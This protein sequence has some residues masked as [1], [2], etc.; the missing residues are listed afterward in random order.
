MKRLVIIGGGFTGSLVA[1]ALENR[2]QTT[3]IDTK[4]FFEFTPGILRLAI[5]PEHI[6][7]LQNPHRDYLEKTKIIIDEVKYISKNSILLKN[8]KIPF[9]YLVIA[10]GSKYISPIKDKEIIKTY[11]SKDI[12]D[13]LNKIKKAK[14]IAIIGGGLVGV[15]LAAELSTKHKNKK[16][17]IIHSRET[18]IERNYHKSIKKADSFLKRHDVKI[19]FNERAKSK[20]GNIIITERGTKI[21][22]DL[23][24]FCTGITPN[25]EFMKPSFSQA[26]S[27]KGGIKV[28]QFL[29]VENQKN[30]FAGGDVT[31]IIEEKTAQSSERHAKTIVQNII[32]L[33]NKFPL[34]EYKSV[35]RPMLISLGKYDGILEYKSLVITGFPAAIAKSLVE[36]KELWKRK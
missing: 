8:K 12:L 26:I 7:K 31:S 14:S 5:E 27:E 21:P 24:F 35:K 11:T 15:E 4:D 29:Q 10:T 9:D 36:M 23:F 34:I 3:L 28:N 33:E 6:K 17:T 22:A 30:I 20:R 16:I 19:I 2:F 25:S 18:L 1:K 13:N 32:N